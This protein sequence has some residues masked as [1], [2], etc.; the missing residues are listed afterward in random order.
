[1]VILASDQ[2]PLKSVQ[3]EEHRGSKD[4]GDKVEMNNFGGDG[5]RTGSTASGPG[6]GDPSVPTEVTVTED[7]DRDQW[8]GKMDFL[9][10]C[11]GYAIGLGNVSTIFI[12]FQQPSPTKYISSM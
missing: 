7:L 9:M 2:E 5:V 6:G 4:M 8:T 12:P 1:M 11:I 3:K 10:S